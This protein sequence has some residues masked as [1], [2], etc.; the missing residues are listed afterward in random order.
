MEGGRGN[1][2]AGRCPS[3][4]LLH[5]L[6]A[7]AV[8]YKISFVL[9]RTIHIPH[10]FLSANL[11]FSQRVHTTLSVCVET[12]D[13][14]AAA[15]ILHLKGKNVVENEHVKMGQ[16]HTLDL[17]LGKKFQLSKPH[18]DSVDLDRL[19]LALDVTQHADVAAVVMH[20][21]LAHVCLLTATMTI[22][23]RKRKGLSGH[24]DKG[25]MRFLDAI[26]AAFI[27]HVNLKVVKCVLVASRGFLNEQFLNHL[28]EYADK[29]GN[30]QIAENRSKF[31]LVHS[32]SGYKHALNEVLADPAV[33]NA[34]SETKAQGEVK[35]LGTFFNLMATE[36]ARAFYGLKHV[37]KANEQLAIESLLLSDSLFR[38]NDLQMRK[39]YVDLVE[40]V[41][42][43]GAN[44]LIFSSMH[45]SGEQLSL[46][47]G[48]AAILRF[49]LHE[50]D[51]EEM[52]DSDDEGNANQ[53]NNTK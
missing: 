16:Y 44:V 51:E 36:P 33:A 4:I 40:S 6:A 17:I 18:W 43:Q 21:G 25:L 35:A 10:L 28:L 2:F 23:P 8:V 1:N 45:P 48:V 29:Q 15:C 22:I 27:R 42:A 32:S 3:F 38:S 37:L 41:K 7:L 9:I 13:F 24:H 46:L 5:I 34:L 50:L 11:F 49:P 31:L 30:K 20:E 26:A 47:S 14:D 12:V 19:N 52:S 39:K 53:T